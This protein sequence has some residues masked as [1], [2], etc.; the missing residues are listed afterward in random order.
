MDAD[1]GRI[2][3]A[4]LTAKEG[5]DGAGALLDQ[6]TGPVAAFIGDGGCGQDGVCASVAHRHT[7]ERRATAVEVAVHTLTRMLGLGRL[8]SVRTA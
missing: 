4:S 5:G 7:D 3:A 1:T 2:V 6:I 8:N